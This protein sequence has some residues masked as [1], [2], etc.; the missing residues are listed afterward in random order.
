M[1]NVFED[2]MRRCGGGKRTE[3]GEE[4]ENKKWRREEY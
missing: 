1:K 2:I 3:S 4:K